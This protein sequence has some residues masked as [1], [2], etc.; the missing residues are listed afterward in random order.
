VAHGPVPG[1]R[2]VDGEGGGSTGPP[3]PRDPGPGAYA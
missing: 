2:V 3:R 1:A